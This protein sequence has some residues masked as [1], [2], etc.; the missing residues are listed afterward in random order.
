MS[1]KLSYIVFLIIVAALA[2]FDVRIIRHRKLGKEFFM[3]CVLTA[4]VTVMGLH[5]L[6]NPL[7]LTVAEIMANILHIT[8]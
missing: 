5:Y 4:I 7:R 1:I 6:S 3:Y 8:E 2:A